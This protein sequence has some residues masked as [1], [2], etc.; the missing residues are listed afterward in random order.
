MDGGLMPRGWQT[1]EKVREGQWEGYSD[2]ESFGAGK[3]PPGNTGL[4]E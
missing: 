2:D 3:D 1:K 4:V